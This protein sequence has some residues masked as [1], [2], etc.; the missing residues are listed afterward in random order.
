MNLVHGNIDCDQGP[1]D[2][3]LLCQI[4]NLQLTNG[5]YFCRLSYGK[6][7]VWNKLMIINN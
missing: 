1:G 2:D 4:G 7:E 3:Y 6:N 5:V